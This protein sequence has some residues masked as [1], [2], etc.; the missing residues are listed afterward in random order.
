MRATIGDMEDV[1]SPIAE[2]APL[3]GQCP[4]TLS[5]RRVVQPRHSRRQ[6]PGVDPTDEENTR[7]KCAWSAKPQF[8]A[9]SAICI[10]VCRSNSFA[11]STLRLISQRCGGNPVLRAKARLKW[12]GDSL[13]SAATSEYRIAPFKFPLMSSFALRSCQGARPPDVAILLATVAPYWPVR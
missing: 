13:H 3:H 1:Q 11:K 7:V 4:Q 2:P 9:I 8:K 5:G 10:P 6:R 12:P